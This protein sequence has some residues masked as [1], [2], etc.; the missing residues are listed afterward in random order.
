MPSGFDC[1][2]VYL[3]GSEEFIIGHSLIPITF[4]DALIVR[5]C[6]HTRD[7]SWIRPDPRTAHPTLKMPFRFRSMKT[8]YWVYT[9]PIFLV[10]TETGCGAPD[11][12]VGALYSEIGYE[13]QLVFFNFDL[14]ALANHTT[15]ACDGD[16]PDPAPDYLPGTYWGR[17]EI[18]GAILKHVFGLQPDS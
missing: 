8:R 16:A 13:G 18:I 6:P 11:D 15:Q 14:S 17:V 4:G 7:M 10:K 9:Q 1:P 3:E 12:A 5:G 2:Y